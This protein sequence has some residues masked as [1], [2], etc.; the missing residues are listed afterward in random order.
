M[1]R[2]DEEEQKVVEKEVENKIQ[3]FNKRKVAGEVFKPKAFENG[4]QRIK[5][6]SSCH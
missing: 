3:N 1:K 5:G 6:R 4:I 2:T